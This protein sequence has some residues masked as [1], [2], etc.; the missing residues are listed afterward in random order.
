M[1]LTLWRRG[2][3]KHVVEGIVEVVHQQGID[4]KVQDCCTHRFDEDVAW[5]KVST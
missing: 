4:L 3:H 1:C 5:R 2:R